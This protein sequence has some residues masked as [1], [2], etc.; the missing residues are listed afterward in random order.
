M[1]RVS[2]VLHTWRCWHHPKPPSPGW[3]G[4]RRI[5]RLGP[6][7]ARWARAWTAHTLAGFAESEQSESG[8]GGPRGLAPETSAAALRPAVQVRELSLSLGGARASPVHTGTVA[9]CGRLDL[10]RRCQETGALRGRQGRKPA[11]KYMS[12][13]VRTSDFPS[14]WKGSE[15]LGLPPGLVLS[16]WPAPVP[17]RLGMPGGHAG[18]CGAPSLPGHTRPAGLHPPAHL[19]PQGPGAE[20]PTPVCPHLLRSVAVSHSGRTLGEAGGSEVSVSIL[21]PCLAPGVI[22]LEILLHR[23][24]GGE[25]EGGPPVPKCPPGET[26]PFRVSAHPGPFP[27]RTEAGGQHQVLALATVFRVCVCMHTCVYMRMFVHVC[28][29]V[30]MLVCTCANAHTCTGACTGM[31]MRVYVC[32]CMQVYVCLCMHAY[33]CT[34]L[35]HAC[36]CGCMC[37]QCLCMCV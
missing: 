3:K 1:G 20:E 25:V 31:Y 8:T 10:P 6:H 35:V 4:C 5:F 27:A 19:L 11:L 7:G 21:S 22:L 16:A 33:M 12:A 24:E 23:V 32:L 34:V 26:E 15:A 36:A 9:D 13:S 18:S 17:T 29:R 37:A 14:E 30:H 2:S 28:I